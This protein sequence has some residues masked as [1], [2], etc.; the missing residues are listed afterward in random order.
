MKLF[1]SQCDMI[2]SCSLESCVYIEGL[3]QFYFFSLKRKVQLTINEK[4]DE[5]NI[6]RSSTDFWN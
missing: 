4:I 5:L 3:E 1:I 6:K 2:P